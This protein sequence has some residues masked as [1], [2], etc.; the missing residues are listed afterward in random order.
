M[1]LSGAGTITQEI[2]H[3]KVGKRVLVRCLP[4]IMARLPQA[5][6]LQ[7]TLEVHINTPEIE[8]DHI[9]TEESLKQSL[10]KNNALI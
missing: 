2:D 8:V 3:T 9:D 1:V 7:G 10:C 4:Y 6:I 5:M